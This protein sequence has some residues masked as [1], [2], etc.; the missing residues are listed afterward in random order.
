MD[1]YDELYAYTM[2]R[3]NFILQLFVNPYWLSDTD[4][5]MGVGFRA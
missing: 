3:K 2:G 5:W 4:G 1:E